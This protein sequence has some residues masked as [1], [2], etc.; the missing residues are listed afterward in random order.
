MNHQISPIL[1]QPMCLSAFPISLFST[2]L[3][4]N[5]PLNSPTEREKKITFFFPIKAKIKR[6][7]KEAAPLGIAATWNQI[8]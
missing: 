4:S 5:H 3:N 1:P 7:K 8:M 2:D 6:V